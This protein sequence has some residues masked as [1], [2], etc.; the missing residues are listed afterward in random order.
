MTLERLTQITS[1][2]ISS[3]IT[4]NSATLTG[5]TTLTTLSAGGDIDAVNGTFS[6]N[7]TIGGTLTYEDV[8]NI[9]SIGIITTRADSAG[10]RIEIQRTNANGTGAVGAVNWTA[11]DNH[12]VAS[13]FA[14]AD[15][16]DE[17]AHL[18]FKTTSDAGENNPYGDSTFRRF[19]IGSDGNIGIGSHDP[20]YS[21]DIR[22]SDTSRI[23]LE[24]NDGGAIEYRSTIG[25]D[26][27]G[28]KIQTRDG[29]YGSLVDRVTVNTSGNV[30]I[31]ST[32][33]QAKLD[34]NG[35]AR[36]TGILTVG[37]SSITFNGNTNVITLGDGNI[38]IGS[39]TLITPTQVTN[40]GVGAELNATGTGVT[41]S[42]S[43]T[44]VGYGGTTWFD[45]SQGIGYIGFDTSIV[46]TNG[47]TYGKIYGRSPA[48][49]TTQAE[50]G[51]FWI[52]YTKQSDGSPAP[53]SSNLSVEPIAGWKF[54][55]PYP[56]TKGDNFDFNLVDSI[57]SF[58]SPTVPSSGTYYL[59]W[60]HSEAEGEGTVAGDW[61]SDEDNI[62]RT[63][64]NGS[65]YW[66]SDPGNIGA[67][68]S[69]GPGAQISTWN[70]VAY[71][72][73]I[74]FRFETLPKI[75]LRGTTLVSPNIVDPVFMGTPTLDGQSMVGGQLA[76]STSWNETVTTV[77]YT[78]SN[79]MDSIYMVS[80]ALS[81]GPGWDT[82]F[83]Q[84]TDHD[85]NAYTGSGDYSSYADWYDI[86]TTSVTVGS[87][88]YAG[89]EPGLWLTGNGREFFHHGI[90]WIIP[91]A[92][93]NN[94]GG[95]S[96]DP[97]KNANSASGPWT[98]SITVRGQGFLTRGSGDNYRENGGG[99]YKNSSASVSGFRLIGA[100]SSHTIGTGSSNGWLSVWRFKRRV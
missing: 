51:K 52:L 60:A 91:G 87:A 20:Q 75:D 10:A 97:T 80:Y 45:Y 22:S 64:G 100:D 99:L 36:I 29:T 12:S 47:A 3:G 46:L 56:A 18:V 37:E 72:G 98:P 76:Y 85:G 54:Q 88:N 93:R 1:V 59:G 4:L 55:L 66:R 14:Q 27:G 89:D 21:L 44:Y 42:P 94:L 5:V 65:I 31:A 49:V 78:E 11:V 6:G 32:L 30:G 9:D 38:G 41:W 2:G 92:I 28:F 24:S 16:D 39:T 67:G 84:F 90:Y 13:I 61:W 82:T 70:G 77:E 53:P 58:G 26:D 15:G 83:M 8:T 57:E 79:F 19:S 33:P 71:S 86:S 95:S 17:G 50:A 23:Y 40:T 73:G 96:Y 25:V 48:T 68:I 7:V 69:F 74:H 62:S 34:V 81:G 43:G 63:E 35:D